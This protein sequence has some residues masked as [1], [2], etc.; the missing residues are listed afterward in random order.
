[1]TR[2][3]KRKCAFV[4]RH[5]IAAIY[6][7]K[8][9]KNVRNNKVKFLQL[10]K[11]IKKK[12]GKCHSRAKYVKKQMA[13]QQLN[14][15]WDQSMV[16]WQKQD[17]KMKRVPLITGTGPNSTLVE[18]AKAALEDMFKQSASNPDGTMSSTDMRNYIL[19][20]CKEIYPWTLVENA[21][22]PERIERIFKW[23]MPE[24]NGK[25]WNL[26]AFLEWYFVACLERLDHVWNDLSVFNYGYDLRKEDKTGAGE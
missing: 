5:Q 26:E 21:A 17:D 18:P 2:R 24:G 15:A 19:K 13:E 11:R 23:Y 20:C 22:S 16:S 25:C 14:T 4:A 1:M 7:M 3:S 8:R 10:R 6:R 12:Q 9:S